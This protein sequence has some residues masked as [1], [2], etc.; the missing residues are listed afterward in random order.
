[1]SKFFSKTI[2]LTALWAIIVSMVLAAGILIAAWFGVNLPLQMKDKKTLTVSLNA[3]VYSTQ[4][5]T[6]KEDLSDELGAE[7]VLE[8]AMSGDVSEIVFVFEKGAN[9]TSLKTKAE[10]Y[11]ADKVANADGWA[12]AKYSV[13]AS[14]EAA[15]TTLA[16]GYFLRAGIACAVLAFLAF[17][18]VA[19]R[20]KAAAAIATLVSVG[21]SMLLTTALI[22]VTRVYVTYSYV[23]ALAGLLTAVMMLLTLNN[24]R[25]A[26]KDGASEEDIVAS[27]EVLSMAAIVALGLIAVAV[28]GKT[29]GMWF[30]VSAFIALVAATFMSLFFAPAVYLSIKKA[31]DDMPAKEGYI[32]AKKTS[33]KEKKVYAPKTEE[34]A[35]PVEEAVAE[36]AEEVAEEP[37]EEEVEEV[38]EQT[39]AEEPATEEV[40]EEAPVE[41]PATEEVVE[42]A[43]VEE[44]TTEEVA[45][46]ATEEKTEE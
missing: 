39:P 13:S 23:V 26:Q 37:V 21:L 28:L 9:L 17:I 33:T 30:A 8:G 18:Y 24:A 16:K 40:V 27:K 32:G 10:A 29:A 20:Y 42:E 45:E 5:D 35:A 41:E 31:Y 44:P 36:P 1:M 19:I 14:T 12:G 2:K 38:V 46:E 6:V 43:P 11:L 25:S 3:Y 7:Y 15:T 22:V 34:V 4:L